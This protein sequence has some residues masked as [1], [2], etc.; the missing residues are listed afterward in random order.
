MSRHGANFLK[1]KRKKFKSLVNLQSPPGY[2][3]YLLCFDNDHPRGLF[4]A[5]NGQKVKFFIFGALFGPLRALGTAERGRLASKTL[6]HIVPG[7]D[8]SISGAWAP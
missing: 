3:S 4:G 2:L 6:P 5:Q 8:A 1:A 7:W